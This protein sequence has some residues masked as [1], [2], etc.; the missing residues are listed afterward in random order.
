MARVEFL[1]DRDYTENGAKRKARTGEVRH[2]LD[3]VAEDLRN[4]GDAC[5][6]PE[7]AAPA[8]AAITVA[9][10][11]RQGRNYILPDGSKARS[12]KAAGV[13]LAAFLAA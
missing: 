13:A 7:G 3:S 2:V 5:D 11:E 6:A 10:L 9:D 1:R 8:P 12:K 4:A